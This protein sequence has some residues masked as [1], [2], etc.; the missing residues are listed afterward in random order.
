MET[1]LNLS[2]SQP[3]CRPSYDNFTTAI[4]FIDILASAPNWE[5]LCL[6]S[7]CCKCEWRGGAGPGTSGNRSLFEIFKNS[8]RG[9]ANFLWRLLLYSDGLGTSSRHQH[10]QDSG[11]VASASRN[12]YQRLGHGGRF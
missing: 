1:I 12:C 10:S 9:E 8:K 7:V 3:A 6:T 2:T 11:S 4:R 5:A